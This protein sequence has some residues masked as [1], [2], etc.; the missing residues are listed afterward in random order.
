MLHIQ[1]FL[2]SVESTTAA[3]A[4]LM[5]AYAVKA[6]QHGKHPNLWLFK[7]NQIE[8]PF[9]EPLV[10]ECR[11]IILDEANDW[12]VVAMPYT[13]FFNHG[14]TLAHD[15][16]WSSAVAFDKLDG[17]IIT[18]YHYAGTWHVSTSGVPD[19][20]CAVG[21]M[22]LTFAQLFWKTFFENGLDL[23][24]FDPTHCYMFELCA[25]HNRVVV[26]YQ[27]PRLYLH[28]IRDISSLKEL[29]VL[30]F[31][32]L[33]TLAP[34][35]PL[36]TIEDV[37]SAAA[38]LN[39]LEREGFVVRDKY[40]RRRKVKCPAYVALHHCK[41]G[42]MSRRR[43]ALMIRDG[44]SEEFK[45][46]LDAFPE[47]RAEFE[48]LELTYILLAQTAE[49][50]YDA[51]KHIEDQK[52]FALAAKDA[53]PKVASFLFSM[54]KTKT[55]TA[56]AAKAYMKNLTAPAYLRLVGVKESKETNA[57]EA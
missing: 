49:L 11:G 31:A 57:S 51:L 15:I 6:T 52:E 12:A 28:G 27:E 18:M 33:C 41:D 3:F 20:S 39:P 44:E 45:T 34:F 17:S 21:D 4:A 55:G 43:V 56:S 42:L 16:D 14:E 19:A 26:R 22:G 10:Q 30:D 5:A 25:P 37:V 7:Y 48:K 35:Y 23:T 54:R 50:A 1:K 36:Q 13:K 29:D 38:V 46:A 2:R 32:W 8:S 9:A 47:L 53:Y 40:F 24:E